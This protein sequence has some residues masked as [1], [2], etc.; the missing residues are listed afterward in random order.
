MKDQNGVSQ[1]ALLILVS[2]HH[3]NTEKVANVIGRVLKAPVVSPKEV[4]VGSMEDCRLIGFGSGI[5][6]GMHHRALPEFAEK[7]PKMEGKKVF[8]LS[9]SAIISKKKVA[10]DHSR[11]REILQKKGYVVVDEFTC[12]GFNTNSFLRFFGRMNKG[13]PNADDLARADSFAIGL[14]QHTSGP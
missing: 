8:L 6:D 12:K 10:G 3:Q 13:R 4:E 1:D 5:Y 14:K 2:Y 7:L 11:L 9:T